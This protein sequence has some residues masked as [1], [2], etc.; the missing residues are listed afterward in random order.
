MPFCGRIERRPKVRLTWRLIRGTIPAAAD[1][2]PFPDLRSKGD[3]KAQ[4][5][6]NAVATSVRVKGAG[7]KPA[8]AYVSGQIGPEAW[9]LH[10][11]R[12]PDEIRRDC[13]RPLASGWYALESL[14]STLS[15]LINAR[16]SGDPRAAESS[17][18]ELGRFVAEDNLSTVY[19]A[20]LLLAKPETIFGM[21]PRLWNTYF[22]GLQ[23]TVQLDG[24][25]IG[26][27]EVRGLGQLPWIAPV[28]AGWI[29]FA[30][31]KAGANKAD[32]SERAWARG[33]DQADPLMFDVRWS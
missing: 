23:A 26:R 32:V 31:R 33:E 9:A 14:V 24:G 17:L 22:D 12:L 10:L 27:C 7:L 30:L 13:E 6:M 15:A 2:D 21:L 29:E 16:H 19:R 8:V 25:G 11:S 18:R 28:A 1:D 5:G 4:D 20:F 3:Q